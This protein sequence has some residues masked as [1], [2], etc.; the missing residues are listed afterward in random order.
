MDDELRG[1]SSVSR[2]NIV[3]SE[4]VGRFPWLALCLLQ[5]PKPLDTVEYS[6]PANEGL[7]DRDLNEGLS[8]FVT[9]TVQFRSFCRMSLPE[10]CLDG[11]LLDARLDDDADDDD[12]EF[13]S[14][15]LG[16]WFNFSTEFSSSGEAGSDIF[17]YTQPVERCWVC[18][19]SHCGYMLKFLT[20]HTSRSR[21]FMAIAAIGQAKASQQNRGI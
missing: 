1:L 16:S 6:L 19:I 5:E 21:A 15:G 3:A 18:S 10:D 7:A 9:E 17:L 8:S 12:A 11:R 2:R 20:T 4:F 14:G 13:L